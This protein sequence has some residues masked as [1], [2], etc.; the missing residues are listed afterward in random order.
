M[1]KGGDELIVTI[2]RD[3]LLRAMSR[4]CKIA[5]GQSESHLACVLI[6][7]RGDELSVEANDLYESCSV[8]APAIVEEPGSA[9]VSGKSLE[10]IVKSMSEGAVTIALSPSGVSV[11]CGRA[12][13]GVPSLDPADFPSFPAPESGDT[14]TV[15]ADSLAALVK[16]CS[17]ACAEEGKGAGSGAGRSVEGVL[18][19]A[20]D[21][22][23]RLTGTDGLAM[24]RA[25]CEVESTGR[26]RESFP[27][28]ILQTAAA[29]CSGGDVILTSSG[30]Q[31][32]LRGEGFVMT[33][34]AYSG[35]YPEC[36]RFFSFEPSC[37]VS[38]GR[39]VALEAA[40][41]AAVIPGSNPVRIG[42]D[43]AGMTFSRSSDRES[44]S[45]SV[46]ANVS[47]PCEIGLNAKCLAAALGCLSAGN[48]EISM[49]DP[50]KPF[51]MRA[52]CVEALLMPVR[53]R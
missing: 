24:V 36:D 26:M 45:E 9:L 41:R 1:I 13:F 37:T 34:R 35:D 17:W 21:G 16:A 46:D 8:T 42:F 10:A 40:R 15:P 52:G 48:V 32:R 18:V 3:E 11:S 29:A 23:L 19:E 20:G 50:L 4:P 27:A 39:S 25:K 14:V 33:A 22:S 5:K 6:E 43:D 31:L 44:M 12:E 49:T 51:V 53:M 47:S 2:S 7:A 38:V 30:S 28:A